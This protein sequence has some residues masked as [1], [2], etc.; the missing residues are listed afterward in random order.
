[1]KIEILYF[2]DCPNY[3]PT[4]TLLEQV[5]RA[6]NIQSDIS[7]IKVAGQDAAR[8]LQFIGS[9][10][11]RIDGLDIEPEA[12]TVAATGLACRRYNGGV[13]SQAMIR[14]ALREAQEK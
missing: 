7:K 1:M 9:P 5:L 11:I 12:R 10:T 14:A 2:S 13:P 8:D 6:E 4:L 3:S